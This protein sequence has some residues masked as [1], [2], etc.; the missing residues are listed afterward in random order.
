MIMVV[1]C[2]EWEVAFGQGV[3]GAEGEKRVF[4]GVTQKIVM[5]VVSKPSIAAS[6]KRLAD[7]GSLPL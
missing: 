4:F 1:S 7:S 6:P 3:S 5:V 2:I